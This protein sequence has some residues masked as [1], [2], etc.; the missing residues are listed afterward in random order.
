MTTLRHVRAL[1]FD[2]DDTLWPV[3]PVI[4]HAEH[5][6]HAFLR[7][8][9]P[10]IVEQHDLDSMRDRRARIG[11]AHPTMRHDFTWLR[12]EALRSHAREAGYPDEERLA[13]EAFEVF[14]RA[15]NEV[16]LY[17][18]VRPALV[19]LRGRVR[20]F[21]LSNGNAD[22]DRVG[23]GG[24]FEGAL[25]ARD[26]GML[27]PDPRIFHQLLQAAGLAPREAAHV[28]DDPEADV[29]GARGAGLTPVWVNRSGAAWPHASP[30]PGLSVRSLEELPALL[31][32]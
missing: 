5:A 6:M 21:A 28:G 1:I 4:L 10:R 19:R 12:L 25:A 20:L 8:R 24:L 3:R 2:L 31:G 32:P 30:A 22:L 27:K 13:E 29:L 14:Y 16:Q 15:R 11:L 23:L 9:Y 26:A 7:E 17:E 18:D